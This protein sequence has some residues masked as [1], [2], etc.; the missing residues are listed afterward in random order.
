LPENTWEDKAEYKVQLKKLAGQFNKNFVKY[1][2]GTPKE[3][4]EKGGPNENF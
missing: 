3:V 1:M 4:V 2:D